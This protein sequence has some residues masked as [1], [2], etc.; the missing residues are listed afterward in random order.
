M[1]ENNNNLDKEGYIQKLK[2]LDDQIF[3]SQDR[4]A[5]GWTVHCFR[6][7][8]F[9]VEKYDLVT[10]K[11]RLYRRWNNGKWEYTCLLD[12]KIGLVEKCRIHPKIKKE[13]RYWV[14]KELKHEDIKDI[15]FRYFN[16][17]ISKQAVSRVLNEEDNEPEEKEEEK[18]ELEK[19]VLYFNIDETTVPVRGREGKV[20]K[21]RKRLVSAYTGRYWGEKG[22]WEL[23]NKR[24]FVE[25]YLPGEITDNYK[26]AERLWAWLDRKYEVN[27]DTKIL[28]AVDGAPSLNKIVSLIKNCI[29][30]ASKFHASRN[31]FDKYYMESVKEGVNNWKD[32][33]CLGY[34]AEGDIFRYLKKRLGAGNRIFSIYAYKKMLL[35]KGVYLS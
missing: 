1:V 13:I 34:S 3:K 10:I 25:T 16:V 5:Q 15:I 35:W 12:S 20:Y 7:R 24:V 8:T 2:Q 31:G 14:K 17:V 6:E 28:G 29:P 9:R 23:S 11:R 32:P 21:M 33:D 18:I 30:V 19:P 22:R 26:Y 4:I 27:E